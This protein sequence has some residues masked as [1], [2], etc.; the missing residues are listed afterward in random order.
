MNRY[1]YIFGRKKEIAKNEKQTRL[2]LCKV[3]LQASS[4][5]C[6][7]PERLNSISMSLWRKLTPRLDFRGK[8][9]QFSVATVRLKNP[10]QKY[11]CRGKPSGN[12]TRLDIIIIARPFAVYY[13]PAF[14][15]LFI[16]P[17]D[18]PHESWQG[19]VSSSRCVDSL[20]FWDIRYFQSS[21]NRWRVATCVNEEKRLGDKLHLGLSVEGPGNS[22][23]IKAWV[24]SSGQH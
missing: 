15:L 7:S 11:I 6:I 22:A 17:H 8:E 21:R 12:G 19:Q 18:I 16:R 13:N 24:V 3:L 4:G 14:R 20:K 2:Q 1:L 9:M 23:A 5:N 10:E